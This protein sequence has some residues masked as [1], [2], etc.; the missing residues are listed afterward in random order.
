MC[1]VWH[2]VATLSTAWQLD[3]LPMFLLQMVT[4]VDYE[5]ER[6]CFTDIATHLAEL[7][8]LMPPMPETTAAASPEASV[9]VKGDR[10]AA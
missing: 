6:P 8:S 5:Q 9:S 7:Y 3:G 4:Q 2:I 1:C 10:A